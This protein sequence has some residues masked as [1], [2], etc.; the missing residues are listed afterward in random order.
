MG[1]SSPSAAPP[2]DLGNEI[3]QILGQQ[4]NLIGS[5]TAYSPG[6]IGL[7]LSNLD[8]ALNGQAAGQRL[9]PVNSTTTAWRNTKT[10]Q[11]SSTNP[12]D[13]QGAG[14]RGFAGR[15]GG[16]VNGKPS[17]WQ[18]FDQITTT[19]QMQDRP[20]QAGLIQQY[21]NLLP[22]T[23]AWNSQSRQNTVNDIRS[24]N[25]GQAS[26]YDLLNQSA[27]QGLKA[28]STIAPGDS[29]KIT[30]GVRSSWA[31]RGVG[32]AP[33]A[34]LDEALQLFGGGQQLLQQR[35]QTAGNVAQL[36]NQLYNMPALTFAQQTS[37]QELMGYGAQY[38]QQPSILQQLGGYG[39]DL[40]NTNFNADQSNRNATANANN[41]TTAGA[42]T[43][44]VTIA[45]AAL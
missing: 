44:A 38:G 23:Q 13:S 22:Q 43:A 11:I 30:N 10:G 5:E 1:K 35:Q 25:P 7:D 36:G 42:T 37:P 27:T 45:A 28:G 2:R 8:L 3:A 18:Q 41:A 17:D 20:A 9:V 15:D 24:M 33:S 39:S 34:Q 6:Q 26:L 40:F 21:G 29:W 12:F 31:N 14:T 16:R 4:G 19:Q 32:N